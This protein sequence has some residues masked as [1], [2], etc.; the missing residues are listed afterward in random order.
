MTE[1]HLDLHM[2]EQRLGQIRGVISARVVPGSDGDIGEVHILAAC[3]RTPKQLVRDIESLVLL[4]FKTKLDYRKISIV[5]LETRRIAA[6]SRVR[7]KTVESEN[8]GPSMCCGVTLEYESQD[9]VGRWEGPLSTTEAEGAASATV[10]ALRGLV[11]E[12]LV[13]LLKEA[14]EAQLDEGQVIIA[15]VAVGTPPKQETLLGSSFVKGTVAE[16]S[17]RAVLSALNRRLP[18]TVE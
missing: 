7:L 15:S 14:K 13:L 12:G 6:A 17:A 8:A 1:G 2:L 10:N 16:A 3:Q 18:F 9:I 4:H 11:G 5:Q